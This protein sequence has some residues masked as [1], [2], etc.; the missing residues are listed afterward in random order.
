[1][2]DTR[3]PNWNMFMI[4]LMLPGII[5]SLIG[6]AVGMLVGLWITGTL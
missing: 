6:V 2:A 5:A 3:W 4:W 1:M